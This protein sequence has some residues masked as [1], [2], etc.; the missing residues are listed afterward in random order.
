MT[1]YGKRVRAVAACRP[2]GAF[3]GCVSLFAVVHIFSN[4]PGGFDGVY[5][6]AAN[7]DQGD[8]VPGIDAHVSIRKTYLDGHSPERDISGDRN[9]KNEVDTE[10]KD[11]EVVLPPRPLVQA[12]PA[13]EVDTVRFTGK[14]FPWPERKNVVPNYFT[15]YRGNSTTSTAKQVRFDNAS[16][17]LV[18]LHHNKAAGTTTKECIQTLSKAGKGRHNAPVFSSGGRVAAELRLAQN[19]NILTR[20]GAPNTYFGGY[21]FGWCDHFVK[22]CAYFTVMRDPFDRSLSSH[23]YCKRNKGDQLCTAQV[24][25]NLSLREWALHQGSFFFRQLLFQPE[26]CSDR[27]EWVPYINLDQFPHK[28]QRGENS[29]R[30]APCWFRQK[31]IMNLT[32]T[33]AEEETLLT[34]CLDNLERWFAL[35]MLVN[36]YDESLK[37]AD[38]A[39]KLPIHKLCSGSHRNGGLYNKT[40]ITKKGKPSPSDITKKKLLELRNDPEVQRVLRPDL[41]L[42]EKG[43]EIFNRQREVFN[44]IKAQ[45]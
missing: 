22:P 24:A 40:A 23:T 39:F 15:S 14:T 41:L 37:M 28:F 20:S 34:Y 19:R 16:N 31:L 5:L 45:T 1:V 32:L 38:E 30:V 10:T 42:Y 18:F 29:L 33:E 12:H 43:V 6:A 36:E 26:F 44:K 11:S 17:I 9:E 13:V 2:I 4:F 21:S 8:S 3:L 7:A 27:T 35:I 25:G